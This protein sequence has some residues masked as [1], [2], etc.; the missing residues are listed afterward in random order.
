VR[1]PVKSVT[2][3]AIVG[4]AAVVVWLFVH[5]RD[6]PPRGDRGPVAVASVAPDADAGTD[7]RDAA[8]DDAVLD[9]AR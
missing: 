9:E 6:D 3:G 2:A 1:V 4:T 5:A 8:A 7:A